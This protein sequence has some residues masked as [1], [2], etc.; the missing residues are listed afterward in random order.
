LRRLDLFKSALPSK[1]FESMAVGRPI[2]AALWGEAATLIDQAECGIVV[3]P[4]DA[5]AVHLAVEKLAADPALARRLGE[6]GRAYAIRNFERKDIAERFVELLRVVAS[7]GAPA[8]A[9]G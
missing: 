3:E 7:A 8:A 9:K 4:E 1:M 6:S 5:G 2:V